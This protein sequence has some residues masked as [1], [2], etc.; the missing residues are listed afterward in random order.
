L[1][2]D[3]GGKVVAMGAVKQKA[4]VKKKYGK[5]KKGKAS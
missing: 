2:G 3:P 1:A 4:K 5:N